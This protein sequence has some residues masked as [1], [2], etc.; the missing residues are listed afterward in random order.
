MS[1][2][3]I[4]LDCCANFSGS[5][6]SLVGETSRKMRQFLLCAGLLVAVALPATGYPD[7]FVVDDVSR[8]TDI[9]KI[10]ILPVVVIADLKEK[11]EGV[12]MEDVRKQ[13]ALELA[14]KGYAL[15][16]EKSFARDRELTA[17]EVN[18]MPSE[19]LAVLGPENA[20][21]I[22]ILFVNAVESS[23]ILIAQSS[24]ARMA[25]V[26]LE[27]ATGDVLWSNE[28]DRSYTA[29]WFN[30]G[31]IGMAIIK[32]DQMAIWHAFQKLFE[33]FPERPM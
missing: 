16:R 6:G 25:A 15:R 2:V 4:G 13:L 29:S 22:L 24:D 7:P 20:T 8:I 28:V 1:S 12:L 27:K 17:A 14:L 32:E 33:P 3:G 9:E 30:W 26:L 31:F 10:T 21:H 11:R 18:A 23:N 19:E 5:G